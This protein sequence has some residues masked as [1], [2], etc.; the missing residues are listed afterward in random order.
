MRNL[1]ALLHDLALK[2]G[3]AQMGVT[4]REHFEKALYDTPWPG[5]PLQWCSPE[6]SL[7]EYQ[8]VIVLA[9]PMDEPVYDVAVTDPI[10]GQVT[11]YQTAMRV[12]AMGIVDALRASGFRAAF[13]ATGHI[14]LKLAARLAGLGEIGMSGLIL[15][16]IFGPWVRFETVLTNAALDCDKPLDGGL[17]RKCGACIKA[18]PTGALAPY[19]ADLQ[20]CVAADVVRAERGLIRPGLRGRRLCQECQKACPLGEGFHRPTGT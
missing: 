12:R 11:F 14:P 15:N 17:C 6:E 3:F 16:P 20:L 2:A 8:S 4:G 10:C 9:F 19:I 13:D 7:P 18:C 1:H 5:P